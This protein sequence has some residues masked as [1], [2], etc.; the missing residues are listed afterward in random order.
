MPAGLPLLQSYLKTLLKLIG[1]PA[2]KDNFMKTPSN[3][4]KKYFHS[5]CLSDSFS[6]SPSRFE[7]MP[8]GLP[9]L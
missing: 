8:S 1:S 5:N 3:F 2:H 9:I 7:G 6:K 4:A